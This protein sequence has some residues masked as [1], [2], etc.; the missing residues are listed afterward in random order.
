MPS[1][2]TASLRLEMQGAGENLNT[3]GAPRLN[4]AIH[5]IDQAIAGRTALTLAGDHVLS[6]ANQ[7]DDEARRAMLDLSGAGPA[8][9][10]L[11][12]VSKIYLV[13]NGASGVVTLTT[14][15]GASVAIDPQDVTFVACDGTNV[16]ALGVGGAPLKAYVEGVAWRYNAGALP[17]QTGNAG[18]V[19]TTD[20]EDAGWS[21]LTSLSD[22]QHD[23]N[24]RA[25]AADRRAAAFAYFG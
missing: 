20:G 9:L 14:G 11:P 21:P 19:V 24:L 10:T 1:T 16:F 5:R 15:A 3:W 6:S 23:Q 8:T 13:R 12:G 25:A 4:N 22:Y 17:G 2:Y 7:A 18:K